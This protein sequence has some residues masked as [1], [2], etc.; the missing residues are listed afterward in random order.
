MN[1]KN[2]EIEALRGLAVVAV[3]ISHFGN[4]AYW[5]PGLGEKLSSYGLAA[6]V[7]L[8][9]VISGLVITRAFYGSIRDSAARGPGAFFNEVRSFMIR[10]L[11][12]VMPAAIIW[13]LIICACSLWFNTTTIFSTLQANFSDLVAVA[14]NVSNIYFAKCMEAGTQGWCGYNSVY[15]SVSLEEQFYL[16]FPLIVL[17]PRKLVVVATLAV[18]VWMAHLE[19]GILEWFTRIDGLLAGIC[20]AFAFETA[21]FQKLGTWPLDRFLPRIALMLSLCSAIVMMPVIGAHFAPRAYPEFIT[22]C[23]V[24]LVALA[25]F[26]KGFTFRDGWLRSIAAYIGTRSFALYLTHNPAAWITREL[27]ATFGYLDSKQLPTEP[28]AFAFFAV[29]LMVVMSE[30]TYRLIETPWREW[31]R[32]IATVPVRQAKDTAPTVTP[33]AVA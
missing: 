7:D 21:R 8:F 32:R 27:A 20:L 33:A 6:G 28:M 25:S 1:K 10:R 14:F 29:A 13:M 26:Q 2:M 17:L 30:L 18:V 15:W 4:T 5:V 24:A 11:F 9:F 3:I 31:G 22:L 16:I 19:R 23:C 12:R